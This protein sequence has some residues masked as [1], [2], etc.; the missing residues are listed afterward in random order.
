MPLPFVPNGNTWTETAGTL[1]NTI[2]TIAAKANRQGLII[3]NPS[4]TVM[5]FRVG[6]TATAAAG[7]P[8]PAGTSVVLSDNNIPTALVTVFCAGTAKAYTIYEW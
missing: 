8:I 6:A 2:V 5:T 7:V 3:G 1:T 4:D